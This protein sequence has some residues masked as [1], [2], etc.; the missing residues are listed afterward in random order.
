MSENGRV[1]AIHCG[2][3]L[4]PVELKILGLAHVL[5]QMIVYSLNEHAVEAHLLE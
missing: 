2:P 3:S 4:T 5:F 1:L